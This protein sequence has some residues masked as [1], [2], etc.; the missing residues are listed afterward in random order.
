MKNTTSISV[1][2]LVK[3]RRPHL[4]NLLRGLLLGDTWPDELLI[5]HMNETPWGLSAEL[6][7]EGL[8]E[9]VSLRH[10]TNGHAVG[11][12]ST[13]VEY[14]ASFH[15]GEDALRVRHVALHTKS[16]KLPLA[17]A[18][19]RAASLSKGELLVFLDVDCIPARTFLSD[20]AQ[21][22]QRT[23]G[24]VMSDVHYLAAGSN[25]AGWTYERFEAAA[26]PH[27]RRP[28]LRRGELQR[29]EQYYLFWSLSF[30]CLR[31]TFARIGGF[32]MRFTGYGGEDTDFA[33]SARHAGVPLYLCGTV[34]YHQYHDTINPPLQHLEDII[35][36]A[37]IYKD[38]W[39]RWPMENWLRAF[40]KGGF[41]DWNEK[42]LRL[43]RL[44]TKG[45]LRSHRSEKLFA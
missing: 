43:R 6:E 15:R 34:A 25:K 40:Q 26:M 12:A 18:R 44:P 3:N 17:R 1:L 39:G 24:L 32:D 36:N 33:L 20:M 27:P 16:G 37:N 38:K 14:Q 11:K 45:E 41:V 19:N 23:R 42:R 7:R 28:T 30:A 8:P 22:V 5:V 4:T 9:G 2:T 31:K 35:E 13:S 21:A 29:T 10:F